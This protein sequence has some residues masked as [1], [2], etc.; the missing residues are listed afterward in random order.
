MHCTKAT[1]PQKK[2]TLKNQCLKN[3]MLVVLVVNIIRVGC[4]LCFCSL[5]HYCSWTL[6]SKQI[7]HTVVL[8]HSLKGNGCNLCLSQRTDNFKTVQLCTPVNMIFPH[9]SAKKEQRILKRTSTQ[10]FWNSISRWLYFPSAR[11]VFYA[12]FSITSSSYLLFFNQDLKS[13]L[14]KLMS[15]LWGAKPFPGRLKWNA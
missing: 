14:Y 9:I 10:Q 8:K 5:Y 11:E 13:Q 2:R 4:L 7:H 6:K 15:W 12:P 3:S 1:S